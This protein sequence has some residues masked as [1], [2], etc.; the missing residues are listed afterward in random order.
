MAP[1]MIA[2]AAILPPLVLP[3][4]LVGKDRYNIKLPHIDTLLAIADKGRRPRRNSC[5]IGPEPSGLYKTA[6][7]TVV[8]R[9]VPKLAVPTQRITDLGPARRS[10]TFPE[11]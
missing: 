3:P 1:A 7:D 10:G 11:F 6:Q 9:N 2:T 8:A 5:P 4:W